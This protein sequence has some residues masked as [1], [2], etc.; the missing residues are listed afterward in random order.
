MT[1]IDKQQNSG[2]G[3][4]AGEP[5]PIGGNGAEPPDSN[6]QGTG[7]TPDEIPDDGAPD[8]GGHGNREVKL[9]K[10]AQAAE[11]DRDELRDILAR[12]RQAIVDKALSDAQ[13]DPRLLAAAG[14]DVDSLIGDDGL[15]D[16]AALHDTIAAVAEEFR[17]PKPPNPLR[18]NPQQGIGSGPPAGGSSWS[19][20]LK[21]R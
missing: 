13:L 2:P 17:L 21:G 1:T 6:A 14:H 19:N 5:A 20:A 4:V 12:T 11:A 10:R 7:T 8:D 3:P 18:P 15:I 9:R 16:P